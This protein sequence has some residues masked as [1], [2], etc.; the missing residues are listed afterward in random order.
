[1]DTCYVVQMII[2]VRYIKTLTDK[3]NIRKIVITRTIFMM[4]FYD[5]SCNIDKKTELIDFTGANCWQL[6]LGMQSS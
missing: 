6:K 4:L 3:T 2:Q 1:M 5:F